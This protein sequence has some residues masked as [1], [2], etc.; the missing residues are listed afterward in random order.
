MDDGP[1]EE[2][3]GQQINEKIKG[4]EDN[5]PWTTDH[6]KNSRQKTKD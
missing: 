4:E 3:N 2:D 5:G 1:Q 6:R